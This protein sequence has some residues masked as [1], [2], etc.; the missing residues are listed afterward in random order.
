MKI[1]HACFFVLLSYL[2][3]GQTF[4]E[5]YDN[6]GNLEI[7]HSMLDNPESNSIVVMGTSSNFDLVSVG[8]P[9]R[10]YDYTG[11]VAFSTV[12]GEIG[13]KYSGGVIAQ[14][15]SNNLYCIYQVLDTTIEGFYYPNG[16]IT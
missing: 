12:S 1:L 15:N 9:F 13:L 7:W 3:G 11:T 6:K 14:D 16:E 2:A 10:Q 4:N 8:L 5:L